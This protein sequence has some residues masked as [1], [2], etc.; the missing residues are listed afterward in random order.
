M[1]S[2]D[3]KLIV[4]FGATGQQGGG[5]VHALQAS[6]K[7]KVRAVTRNPEKHRQLADEVVK[8]DL[9]RPE[10]LKIAFNG[11][12]GVCDGDF[13]VLTWARSLESVPL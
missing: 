6:G 4:V 3:K 13:F 5:V 10:T 11:A 7:Y 1:S 2:S 8:A 9:D 12:Y